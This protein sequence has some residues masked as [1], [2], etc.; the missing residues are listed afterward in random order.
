MTAILET[1][2]VVLVGLA[3][4]V[5]AVLL[6]FAVSREFREL[7]PWFWAAAVLASMVAGMTTRRVVARRRARRLATVRGRREM[8][9]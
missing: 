2:I 8:G 9:I 6:V 7:S 3:L 4:G 5:G 1:L